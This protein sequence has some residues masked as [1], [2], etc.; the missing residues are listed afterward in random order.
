[1]QPVIIAAALRHGDAAPAR[2]STTY[3]ETEVTGTTP[4]NISTDVSGV[5]FGK[6]GKSAHM[7][8][9]AGKRVI[10]I[11][12]SQQGATAARPPC[13]SQA[14]GD[15]GWLTGRSTNLAMNVPVETPR[16]PRREPSKVKR[17]DLAGDGSQV[18]GDRFGAGVQT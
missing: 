10:L 1:M 11:G 14:D 7:L 5:G 8:T 6:G 17:T 4:T 13:R 15:Q 18:P 2:A 9:E 3:T 12:R 16:K